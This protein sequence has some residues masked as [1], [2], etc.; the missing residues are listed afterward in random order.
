MA[1]L[2]LYDDLFETKKRPEG[3]QLNK[4]DEVKDEDRAEIV[5][6]LQN[7]KYG[8]PAMCAISG[9]STKDINTNQRKTEFLN[10]SDHVKNHLRNKD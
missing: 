9:F 5:S 1:N 2:F 4:L 8:F 6:Y 3:A 7:A 10:F